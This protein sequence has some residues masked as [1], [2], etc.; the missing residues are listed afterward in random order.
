MAHMDLPRSPANPSSASGV[1]QYAAFTIP[2]LHRK[3]QVE[4]RVSGARVRAQEGGGGGKGTAN[5]VR[6]VQ[7]AYQ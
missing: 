1:S 7:W 6:K 5:G 3:T 2:T 4:E